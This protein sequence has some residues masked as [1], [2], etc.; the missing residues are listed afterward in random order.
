MSKSRGNVITPDPYV[1]ELG[2]DV[3]RTYLMF[4]GPWDQGGEWS[5]AGINGV[6]RWMNRLWELCQRRPSGEGESA[7]ARDLRRKLH[8]T[9][10]KVYQDLERFKFNTAVAVLMELSNQMGGARNDGTIDTN[11]WDECVEKLLLMLA[12]FAPHIAEELWERTGHAYSIH[13]QPFPQW[14]DVLA[15]E[16]VITLVVQVNGKV[17]DKLQVPTDISEEEAKRL[18]LE[19]GRVQAHVGDKQVSRLVYIRGRLVNVVTDN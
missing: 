4:I 14:D 11:T 8:Q 17:R 7:T 15:A 5:D 12:P 19:S 1:E 10:R 6:A 2:A 9:V 13:Q 3:V 16:E 18:A